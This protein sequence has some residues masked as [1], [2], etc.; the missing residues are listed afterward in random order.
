MSSANPNQQNSQLDDKNAP[1]GW[2]PPT[3]EHVAR[4][5]S[6]VPRQKP[7]PAKDPQGVGKGFIGLLN[8]PGDAKPSDD[9]IQQWLEEKH[10]KS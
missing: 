3:P 6:M 2:T 10:L 1:E 4:I 9:Q 8:K 7:K 5:A